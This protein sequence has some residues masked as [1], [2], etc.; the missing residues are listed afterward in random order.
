MKRG[1]TL[2]MVAPAAIVF[3]AMFAGPFI[4]FFVIS[5]WRKQ[6][7]RFVPDFTPANYAD[8]L[9]GANLEILLR[10]VAIAG[11]AALASVTIG[12]VY[13]FVVRFKAGRWAMPMLFAAMTTLF[14]GYLMKIYAWKTILG[15]EGLVNTALGSLG[16]ISAPIEA[17][18]YSPFAVLLT[19]VN[20]LLPF[21][22][23]PIYAAMRGISD[24]ELAAARDLGAGPWR[25]LS[26]VVVPRARN[27][28][29]TAFM[30]SFL[31]AA[32]DYVTPQLVGGTMTMIGNMIALQF[33]Q[34]FNWPL[35]A[36]LSY[37]VLATGLMSILV[38]RLGMSFWRPR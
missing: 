3:L 25:V 26:D 15:N 13:A 14:G 20:F 22:I 34:R 17:L 31:L 33:G 28:I 35:G 4:Y 21:A 38:F 9:S 18:F 2:L 37:V 5:F 32:G 29:V 1:S 10:T 8:A 36:A 27:G 11:T 23:L 16:V 24:A 7:F 12:F 6:S 30:F 19:F